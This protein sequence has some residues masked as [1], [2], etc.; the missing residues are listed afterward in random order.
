MAGSHVAEVLAQ[1]PQPA[2]AAQVAE[3]GHLIGVALVEERE[4]FLQQGIVA[5]GQD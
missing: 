2:H 3:D 5:A 1:R 4:G